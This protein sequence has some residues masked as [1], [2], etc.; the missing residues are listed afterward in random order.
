MLSDETF[1]SRDE[2]IEKASVLGNVT[3]QDDAGTAGIYMIGDTGQS[4]GIIAPF[5]DPMCRS[6]TRIRLSARGALCT[7]LAEENGVSL[8]ELLRSDCQDDAISELVRQAVLKKP[9]SHG[10][11]VHAKMWKIGG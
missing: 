7:C 6:C 9:D 11:C 2:I 5:S 1:V 8:I 10:G 3:R 4:F